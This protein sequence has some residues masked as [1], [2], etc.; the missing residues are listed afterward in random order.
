M[1]VTIDRN[2]CDHVLPA[3][4]QCFARFVLNPMGEDRPCITEYVDDDDPILR[5]TLRYDG[6]EETLV[7]S[8]EEREAVAEDGWSRFVKVQPKF[9]RE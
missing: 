9:Y 2:L 3:C 8:P 7:L 6:Q 1:K 5:L 4:E